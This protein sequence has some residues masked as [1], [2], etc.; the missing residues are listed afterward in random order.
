M[1]PSGPLVLDLVEHG[2]HALIGGTSG[3]G[4]SELL[5]SIVAALIH[6]Y[7]PTRLTF[8][9]VDYK[10]GAA[11]EVFNTVP[12]TV[13]YVTNLDASL[14]L[15]AL[16][17]LRAELN[18]R[19]R[20][21]EGKAKDLAEM[22]EKHPDEA[23]PSLVIVVDE[24]A[25]LVKE[26]PEFVAGVVDIAQRGRS[27]GVHLILATQ[28]PSGSVNDN[29]LANTNLRISLRMLDASESRTVIGVPAA[30]DIPLPLKGRGFAKLGPSDLIEF[31]SAFTGRHAD[32]GGRGEPGHRAPFG[33]L[34]ADEAGIHHRA[35]TA[36][37]A[38]PDGAGARR[39]PAGRA[40]GGE[41][42]A[43]EPADHPPRRAARCGAQGRGARGRRRASRGAR[44]CPRC[45]TGSPSN[46]RRH[47]G[48]RAP[49][50]LHHARHARRSCCPGP[51]SG[52]VRPRGGRR[53]AHRRRRRFGQD[54]GAAHGGAGGGHRCH[55]RRGGPVRDRLRF[56]VAGPADRP[57]ALRRGRDR[58][59]PRVDH[60]GDHVLT[61]ELDRRRAL[62]SDL[63]VQA[64]T[65]SAYLDKGHSLPRIV[66][67]VDGY[68]NLTALLGTVRP[69]EPDRSTGSPSSIESSPMVANS[70]STSCCCRPPAGGPGVADVVDRQPPRAPPDRRR[71]LQRLRHPDGDEQGPRAADRPRAVEQPARPS[72]IVSEDPSAAGQGAA[73][74]EYAE[75]WATSRRELTTSPPPEA[76]RV[77]LKAAAPRVHAR[78]DRRVRDD[79][80]GRRQLHRDVRRRAAP[81]G[82]HDGAAPGRPLAGRVGA[83]GVDDWLGDGSAVPA[84]TS[85]ARPT[86]GRAARGLR[87][88][89]RDV[90]A[91]AAVRARRRQRRPLRATALDS[92]YERILKS[93]TSRL[94]G[95]IET[96]NI[97]GY[98]QNTMLSEIRRE[99][100][101]LFLQ[102]D[103]SSEVMQHV[104]VRPNLRPGFK[105]SA[106]R[107]VLVMD[108]QPH[109]VL[110]ASAT[111]GEANVIVAWCRRRGAVRLRA[112]GSSVAMGRDH[113]DVMK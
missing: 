36:A 85:R 65:L 100:A 98:T 29:I 78:T 64:E 73:I 16:T 57:A 37:A 84:G 17:S 28:R 70:A 60:P 86:R 14:S 68:Q 74:A 11:T 101:L 88:A 45:S 2:P 72:R 13:G 34:L 51:V 97:S 90:P 1:G 42:A 49:R 96:R 22:L 106:G 27:L 61:A 69:S 89:L 38:G 18:H 95:S 31:Q 83:R 110:V 7:P 44:C 91:R 54:D 47:V 105:L 66:V 99:P 30:A 48:A 75:G 24:F 82:A 76:V 62:L 71:R 3:A 108:R 109:V 53:P 67:I 103:G 77:P 79:R 50:P 41:P 33:N 12:H 111:G 8:L 59:R 25:T 9:F 104:G 6:E 63:D 107:G 5:Q 26:V 94:I 23:P 80:R 92:A 4:K 93:E 19:M 58:R 112:A 10:G 87:R 113:M 102:P 56:A 81:L 20:L 21:M 15:R 39:D 40:A 55:A 35:A 32:P 52:R 46:A 43:D